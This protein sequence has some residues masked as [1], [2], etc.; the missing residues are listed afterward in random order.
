V[1][2]RL[3]R[4]TLNGVLDTVAEFTTTTDAS[5]A[6]S[7]QLANVD[8]TGGP[9]RAP[10]SPEDFVTLTYSGTGTLPPGANYTIDPLELDATRMPA[11]GT[12]AE[13]A[14]FDSCDTV[15]FQ[16][17]TDPPQPT[18]NVP[19][20][21]L[22]RAT[23]NPPLT[24]DDSVSLILTR[25]T[26]SNSTQTTVSPTGMLGTGFVPD[27]RPGG[28]PTCEGDLVSGAVACSRLS[29]GS[30]TLTRSRGNVSAAVTQT[31]GGDGFANIPGRLKA[32]DVVTLTKAGSARAITTLHLSPL[33]LDVE[34]FGAS[35]TCA[36]RLWLGFD[37]LCPASGTFNGLGEADA[38]RQADDLSGGGTLVQVPV[39]GFIGPFGGESV[40]APFTAWTDVFKHPAAPATTTL[41][42]FRRNP[43]TSP[44]DFVAG[45][46]TVTPE[47]GGAV[48]G[49]APGRYIGVW[50]VTDTQG[51]D[52]THDTRTE[53][54]HFIVQPG[55]G[56]G[57]AGSNGAPGAQGP[58]GPSG[59][60]GP[61]GPRGP[62]GRNGTVTCKLKG[63][64]R[65]P[66]V[67]CTVQFSGK[68]DAGARSLLVRAG[69]IYAS[70]RAAANGRLTLRARRKVPAGSY[71]LTIV[72]GRGFRT[73]TVGAQIAVR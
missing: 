58:P 16:R 55:G 20:S 48:S 29:A 22:C 52:A 18:T 11:D 65:K 72:G 49:L 53:R 71:V 14:T 56:Q 31:G 30:F 27:V 5:G 57:A 42:I 62:R 3:R 45:P 59:P 6:W 23:F 70:G 10:Y 17:G 25:P 19:A 44:G 41:T 1:T 21:T 4:T 33:R 15:Q 37:A 26:G 69:R 60:Q 61:A 43:D 9:Q 36:P 66:R 28:V 63:K 34:G 7:G 12:F 2:A 24:D 68:F 46:I 50:T 38:R 54:T 35:G 51:D 39:I 13:F 32:G 64:K 8:P 47:S 40:Q 73:Q 67:R